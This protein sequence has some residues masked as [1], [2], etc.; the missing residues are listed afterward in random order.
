MIPNLNLYELRAKKFL[1]LLLSLNFLFLPSNLRRKVKKKEKFLVF[2][3]NIK[4][5]PSKP[6]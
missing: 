2:F 3:W 6:Q 4:E 5:Q 1:L